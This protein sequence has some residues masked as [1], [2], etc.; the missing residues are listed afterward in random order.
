M[1]CRGQ[2]L[3]A[4]VPA[5]VGKWFVSKCI[6][7]PLL[8]L[9]VWFGFTGQYGRH[10]FDF[11]DASIVDVYKDTHA[12]LFLVNPRSA[13]SLA[14]VRYVFRRASIVS[15]LFILCIC[16]EHAKQVP[17]SVCILIIYN[18][19]YVVGTSAGFGELASNFT[20]PE[21]EMLSSSIPISA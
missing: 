17:P 19:R 11:L 10:N 15:S 20:C 2:G 4:T 5:E 13:S 6:L 12:A 9:I 16:R 3:E 7:L 18:F 14:Y 8:S 21:P 1:G